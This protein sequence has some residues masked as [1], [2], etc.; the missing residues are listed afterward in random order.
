MAG[1]IYLRNND[2]S[3][4]AVDVESQMAKFVAKTLTVISC[5]N[6]LNLGTEAV[7]LVAVTGEVSFENQN[8]QLLEV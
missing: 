1:A 8:K 3:S 6:V 2:L 5:I 4:S 7:L